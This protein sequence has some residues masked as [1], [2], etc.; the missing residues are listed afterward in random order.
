MLYWVHDAQ[1]NLGMASEL[2]QKYFTFP[3]RDDSCLCR[4]LFHLHGHPWV[5]LRHEPYPW[6]P[7]WRVL[8][9]DYHYHH[10]QC[11]HLKYVCCSIFSYFSSTRRERNRSLVAISKRCAQNNKW[12]KTCKDIRSLKS[13]HGQQE[14]MNHHDHI[15]DI[16][17]I[18]YSYIAIQLYALQNTS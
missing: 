18:H 11:C 3:D 2:L 12:T 5:V 4:R 14:F 8:Q 13:Q 7:L 9:G 17:D 16:N 10:H 1:G 15:I 6:C